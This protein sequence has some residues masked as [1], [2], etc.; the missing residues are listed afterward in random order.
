MPAFNA[1][2]TVPDILREA[3]RIVIVFSSP[4]KIT[5]K[6]KVRT[7]VS[8]GRRTGTYRVVVEGHPDAEKQ[9]KEGIWPE[10]EDDSE[11]DVEMARPSDHRELIANVSLTEAKRHWVKLCSAYHDQLHDSEHFELRLAARQ[12]A[13]TEAETARA[14]L[15]LLEM[16]YLFPALFV[17]PKCNTDGED[18]FR[19]LKPEHRH[20]AD[21][22][23]VVFFDEDAHKRSPASTDLGEWALYVISNKRMTRHSS[24]RSA[25]IALQN[26]LNELPGADNVV[27]MFLART[28]SLAMNAFMNA[29]AEE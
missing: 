19:I 11:S 10:F 22:Q 13:Q 16:Q 7:V 8:R 28:S 21:L 17:S 1:S 5:C 29:G 15:I 27:G 23:E 18:F 24:L 9:R 25:S 6:P 3:A 20:E 26:E 2:W 14:K 12:H 4:K